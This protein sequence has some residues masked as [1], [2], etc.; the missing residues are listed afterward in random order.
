MPVVVPLSSCAKIPSD[1]I[2]PIQLITEQLIPK[3][4]SIVATGMHKQQK[5]LGP[6]DLLETNKKP[7]IVLSLTFDLTTD[8]QAHSSDSE[9]H[10]WKVMEV[11]VHL[12]EMWHGQCRGRLN[13]HGR[14]TVSTEQCGCVR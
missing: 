7:K 4:F 8:L 13:S 5:H 14:E 3:I 12:I 1:G 6:Q 2:G 10:L 9:C 11:S